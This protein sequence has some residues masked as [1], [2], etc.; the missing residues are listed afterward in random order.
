MSKRNE[1][2]KCETDERTSPRCGDCRK[3]HGGEDGLNRTTARRCLKAV[4]PLLCAAILFTLGCSAKADEPKT[5]SSPAANVSEVATQSAVEAAIQ[6][7]S[8]EG[9]Y[10]FLVFY[11]QDDSASDSMKQVAAQAQ[12]ELAE[13]ANVVYVDSSDQGKQAL[14]AEIG[15]DQSNVPITIVVAPNGA[16]LSGFP[17]EVTIEDLRDAFVSP[18]MADIEKTMQD[19]KLVFLYIANPGMKYYAENLT[20][21]QATAARD[22]PDSSRIIEVDPENA[23]QADVVKAC[24]IKTPVSVTDLLILNGGYIV[25]ELPGKLDQE[26]LVSTITKGCSG[27]SCCPK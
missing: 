3:E 10:T 4:V 8:V 19:G 22:Y 14:M 24:K 12:Q 21:I 15:I 7:A 13:K 25:G 11:Q 20:I 9:K 2:T 5:P 17:K 16:I 6:T 18:Q 27:G 26:T 23:G 1:T